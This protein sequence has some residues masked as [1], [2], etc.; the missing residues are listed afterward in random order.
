MTVAV[1][2]RFRIGPVQAIAL[3][4]RVFT[5]KD[6]DAV[7]LHFQVGLTLR[8]VVRLAPWA[9]HG[10][11]ADVR[12]HLFAMRKGGGYRIVWWLTRGRFARAHTR[13]FAHLPA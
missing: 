8:T 13:A 4:Q 9:L 12:D 7:E 10:V 1:D 3:L 2:R 6:W 5:Q 11:P